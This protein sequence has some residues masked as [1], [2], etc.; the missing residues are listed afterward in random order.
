[1]ELDEETEDRRPIMAKEKVTTP[2]DR[3]LSCVGLSMELHEAISDLT[4]SEP[5]KQV[6]FEK[7]ADFTA[8]LTT[9]REK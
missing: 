8:L 4:I 3:H 7:L 1:M 9:I 5:K 2:T 6:L